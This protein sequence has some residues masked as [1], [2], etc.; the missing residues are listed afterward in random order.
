M[1]KLLALLL[2]CSS[3]QFAQEGED[4]GWVARFGLA[5]GISPVHIFPNIDPINLQVKKMGLPELSSS[6]TFMLGGGGYAYIML[7]DNLR[8]GGIGV[9]GSNSSNGNVGGIEKEVIYSYGFGGLTIEYTLPFVKSFYLS[10]GAILGAGSQTTEIYQSNGDQTWD[11]LWD[12]INDGK[13]TVSDNISN[14][15]YVLSPTINVEVPVNRFMAVRL[16]GGYNIPLFSSWELN[17]G[18]EIKKMP[19]DLKANAFFIQAGIFFGFFA[20]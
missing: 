18:K 20:Y 1:K 5:A 7:V 2:I 4:V 6:G 3:L 14:S 8:L 13:T 10:V 9:K 16:G 19:S 17:N 15:F 11:K 12:K